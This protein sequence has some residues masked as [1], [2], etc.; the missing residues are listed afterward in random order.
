MEQIGDG[1]DEDDNTAAATTTTTTTRTT[2]AAA[3]WLLLQYMA[4]ATN[5]GHIYYTVLAGFF[6]LLLPIPLARA[7]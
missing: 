5:L 2:D 4:V 1:D 7:A 3:P 6:K